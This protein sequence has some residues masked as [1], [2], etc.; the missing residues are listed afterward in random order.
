MKNTR[1]NEDKKITFSC[2]EGYCAQGESDF[3]SAHNHG[4][5]IIQKGYISE[6]EDGVLV[7]WQE[8]RNKPSLRIIAAITCFAFIITQTDLLWAFEDRARTLRPRATAEVSRAQEEPATS[9]G[10][11]VFTGSLDLP[12]PVASTASPEEPLVA[13]EE[14]SQGP[15]RSVEAQVP[16]TA[17]GAASVF[18]TSVG[19]REAIDVSS[20]DVKPAIAR[21][22]ARIALA[23]GGCLALLTAAVVAAVVGAPILMFLGVFAFLLLG[24]YAFLS[25]AHRYDYTG[26][27]YSEEAG[28]VSYLRTLA[29]RDPERIKNAIATTFGVRSVGL[30]TAHIENS[31]RKMG[32]SEEA[33]ARA[34]QNGDLWAAAYRQVHEA[35]FKKF[36][37]QDD[38]RAHGNVEAATRGKGFFARQWI[39]IKISLGI[40]LSEARASRIA[41]KA[42][43]LIPFYVLVRLPIHLF[44]MFI[45]RYFRQRFSYHNFNYDTL[46]YLGTARAVEE[47]TASFAESLSIQDPSMARGM[48]AVEKAKARAM[49]TTPLRV[50]SGLANVTGLSAVIP[51]LAKRAQLYL[52]SY[53]IGGHVIMPLLGMTILGIPGIA[54]V[55]LGVLAWGLYV[56]RGKTLAQKAA[57]IGAFTLGVV[58]LLLAGHFLGIPITEI[59]LPHLDATQAVVGQPVLTF[60]LHN[61]NATV[62]GVISPLIPSFYLQY[63]DTKRKMRGELVRQRF[64]DR[65]LAMMGVRGLPHLASFGFEDTMDFLERL[66]TEVV[67]GNVSAQDY[68]RALALLARIVNTPGI[69]NASFGQRLVLSRAVADLEAPLDVAIRGHAR[70]Q[71]HNE[72]PVDIDAALREVAD[73]ARS[74]TLWDRGFWTRVFSTTVGMWTVTAEISG[75]LLYSHALDSVVAPITSSLGHFVTGHDV[76][77]NP[78][79]NAASFIEGSHENGQGPQNLREAGALGWF[80]FGVDAASKA[81]FGFTPGQAMARVWHDA[82]MVGVST[83]A[84]QT[85][86]RDAR[87]P[88]RN[89]QEA[90]R[91]IKARAGDEAV[92][93]AMFWDFK[94][95]DPSTDFR[96]LAACGFNEVIVDGYCL[97]TDEVGVET[98]ARYIAA[99]H[100]AGIQSMRFMLGNEN[101]VYTERQA[102]VRITGGLCDKLQ[103]VSKQLERNGEDQAAEIIHGVAMDNE[104]YLLKEKWEQSGENA[105]PYCTLDRELQ[106][107]TEEKGFEY[108]R[109]ETYWMPQR[110]NYTPSGNTM[111]NMS[112][113]RNANTAVSISGTVGNSHAYVGGFDLVENAD[114]GGYKGAE[115]QLASDLPGYVQS[116]FAERSGNFK[117]IFVH[118]A[119]ISDFRNAWRQ[120][121]LDTSRLP[122]AG[123]PKGE[124]TPAPAPTPPAAV[125]AP[126]QVPA[127]GRAGGNVAQASQDIVIPRLPGPTIVDIDNIPRWVWE[128]SGKPLERTQTYPQKA[129]RILALEPSRN[130]A[131]MTGYEVPFGGAD[132]AERIQQGDL[133]WRQVADWFPASQVGSLPLEI[134]IELSKHVELQSTSSAVMLDTL[135]VIPSESIPLPADTVNHPVM[136]APDSS[137]TFRASIT[138]RDHYTPFGVELP[139]RPS[140]VMFRITISGVDYLQAQRIINAAAHGPQAEYITQK[141][142]YIDPSYGVGVLEFY[143]RDPAFPS[144]SAKGLNIHLDPGQTRTVELTVPGIS[145]EMGNRFT[146]SARVLDSYGRQLADGRVGGYS[147]N[148][149]MRDY[150]DLALSDPDA[151]RAFRGAVENDFLANKVLLRHVRAAF[152]PAALERDPQFERLDAKTKEV[153]IAL[154]QDILDLSTKVSLGRDLTDA[155]REVLK[156]IHMREQTTVIQIGNDRARVVSMSMTPHEIEPRGTTTLKARFENTGDVKKGQYAYVVTVRNVVTNEQERQTGYIVLEQHKPRDVEIPIVVNTPGR[157][158]ANVTLT[159][160]NFVYGD[161]IVRTQDRGYADFRV[162]AF[163]AEIGNVEQF[164]EAPVRTDGPQVIF[165]KVPVTNNGTMP[166]ELGIEPLS[167]LHINDKV[168]RQYPGIPIYG[169][170]LAPKESRTI[171]VPVVL[172]TAGNYHV[173][174]A[175]VSANA[176]EGAQVLRADSTAPRTHL[177]QETHSQKNVESRTA[178]GTATTAVLERGGVV[179]VRNHSGNEA[180]YTVAM[181]LYPPG[182]FTKPVRTETRELTVAKHDEESADLLSDTLPVGRYNVVYR[183][184]DTQ[185]RELCMLKDINDYSVSPVRV[186]DR[187]FKETALRRDATQIKE[188]D[189]DAADRILLRVAVDRAAFSDEEHTILATTLRNADSDAGSLLTDAEYRDNTGAARRALIDQRKAELRENLRGW[190]ATRIAFLPE[191]ETAVRDAERDGLDAA[192]MARQLKWHLAQGN[193]TQDA[194]R[195]ARDDAQG[196][197]DVEQVASREERDAFQRTMREETARRL[198]EARPWYVRFIEKARPTIIFIGLSVIILNI[199][200]WGIFNRRRRAE[201][202]TLIR[203]EAGE[204]QYGRVYITRGDQPTVTEDLSGDRSISDVFNDMVDQAQAGRQATVVQ[205]RGF[206]LP[207]GRV[208]NQTTAVS[209]RGITMNPRQCYIRL[210][211]YVSTVGGG[212]GN[213]GGFS[214]TYNFARVMIGDSMHQAYRTFA[215]MPFISEARALRMVVTQIM[216]NGDDARDLIDTHPELE[217]REIIQHA[218]DATDLGRLPGNQPFSDSLLREMEQ[219]ELNPFLLGV[220]SAML[221]RPV[222]PE[223]PRHIT[224]RGLWFLYSLVQPNLFLMREWLGSMGARYTISIRTDT[225]TGNLL[226]TYTVLTGDPSM[227]DYLVHVFGRWLQGHGYIQMFSYLGGAPFLIHA[228]TRPD[229]QAMRRKSEDGLGYFPIPTSAYVAQP[230]N[231]GFVRGWM[232]AEP[233]EEVLTYPLSHTNALED[234]VYCGKVTDTMIPSLGATTTGGILFAAS[235]LGNVM[236]VMGDDVYMLRIDPTN[237]STKA[238]NFNAMFQIARGE[239]ACLRARTAVPGATNPHSGSPMNPASNNEVVPMTTAQPV[240]GVSVLAPEQLQVFTGLDFDQFITAQAAQE[241]TRQQYDAAHP[242]EA[243]FGMLPPDPYNTAFGHPRVSDAIETVIGR[244]ATLSLSDAAIQDLATMI[245]MALPPQ[246]AGLSLRQQL[247]LS[248]YLGDEAYRSQV[249]EWI[250]RNVTA[251]DVVERNVEEFE[252]PAGITLPLEFSITASPFEIFTGAV[253]RTPGTLAMDHVARL[254][255]A[256]QVVEFAAPIAYARERELLR[257]PATR[258][259][260]RVPHMGMRLVNI[261]LDYASYTPTVRPEPVVCDF[262][263]ASAQVRTQSLLRDLARAVTPQVSDVT[264]GLLSPAEYT[265]LQQASGLIRGTADNYDSVVQNAARPDGIGAPTIPALIW[266]RRFFE[267]YINPANV[268]TLDAFVIRAL[269]NGRGDRGVLCELLRL[270]DDAGVWRPQLT[271]ALVYRHV[272]DEHMPVV[273]IA[274]EEAR[275]TLREE[276]ASTMQ[277]MGRL[278]GATADGIPDMTLGIWRVPTFFERMIARV[279]GEVMVSLFKPIRLAFHMAIG[280]RYD[281][282]RI[283]DEVTQEMSRRQASATGLL[284]RSQGPV[285][286]EI[287]CAPQQV[288]AAFAATGFES[289]DVHVGGIR[290]LLSDAD[291]ANAMPAPGVIDIFTLRDIFRTHL[292]RANRGNPVTAGSGYVDLVVFEVLQALSNAGMAGADLLAAQII[293]GPGYNAMVAA[294]VQRRAAEDLCIGSRLPSQLYN[295]SESDRVLRG[296]EASMQLGNNTDAK[297]GRRSGRFGKINSIISL[298]PGR[299]VSRLRSWLF[300]NRDI[301]EG[302]T[303]DPQT[304]RVRPVSPHQIH[305]EATVSLVPGTVSPMMDEALNRLVDLLKDEGVFPEVVAMFVEEADGS[306]RFPRVGDTQIRVV[307]CV[308]TSQTRQLGRDLDPILRRVLGYWRNVD[309]IAG[310]VDVQ[311]TFISLDQLDAALSSDAAFRDAVNAGCCVQRVS[312]YEWYTLDN[313][314]ENFAEWSIAHS[315]LEPNTT[316]LGRV[317]RGEHGPEAAPI[318]VGQTVPIPSAG[319]PLALPAESPARFSRA[320]AAELNAQ[321]EQ[322]QAIARAA[323]AGDPQAQAWID[324]W[325]DARVQRAIDSVG[326]DIAVF[327]QC[328]GQLGITVDE[329]CARVGITVTPQQIVDNFCPLSQEALTRGRIDLTSPN[330]A[331]DMLS[332]AAERVSRQ[333]APLNTEERLAVLS[334]MHQRYVAAALTHI[335]RLENDGTLDAQQ[336]ANARQEILDHSIT[337]RDVENLDLD[338][339]RININPDGTLDFTPGDAAGNLIKAELLRELQEYEMGLSSD[340]RMLVSL[341][342]PI[343]SLHRFGLYDTSRYWLAFGPVPLWPGKIIGRVPLL[344]KPLVSTK[345]VVDPDMLPVLTMREYAG[346]PTLAAPLSGLSRSLPCNPATA[347]C[348]LTEDTWSNEWAGGRAIGA[349]PA[350]EPFTPGEGNI[351][352]EVLVATRETEQHSNGV[353]RAFQITAHEGVAFSLEHMA[354]DLIDGPVMTRQRSGRRRDTDFLTVCRGLLSLHT[355]QNWGE[356]V[357]TGLQ[358]GYGWLNYL[359]FGGTAEQLWWEMAGPIVP[360]LARA[361]REGVVQDALRGKIPI[362]EVEE[363]VRRVKGDPTGHL[364]PIDPMAVLALANE[365]SPEVVRAA[366]A[367]H[368]LLRALATEYS[369]EV[370]DAVLAYRANRTALPAGLLREDVDAVS[371]RLAREE[372]SLSNGVRSAVTRFERDV[373]QYLVAVDVGEFMT[374]H[375][376][377]FTQERVHESL[378]QGQWREIAEVHGVLGVKVIVTN[379]TAEQR[380]SLLLRTDTQ[381]L[382]EI[383]APSPGAAAPQT[384]PPSAPE[385]ALVRVNRAMRA[386]HFRGG[387]MTAQAL[388]TGIFAGLIAFGAKIIMGITANIAA[389]GFIGGIV[390][391]FT[392]TAL[393]TGAAALALKIAVPIIIGILVYALVKLLISRTRAIAVATPVAGI[394]GVTAAAAT[395]LGVLALTGVKVAAVATTA[396]AVALVAGK[397]L[398]GVIAVLAVVYLISYLC[399]RTAAGRALGPIVSDIFG[400][401]VSAGIGYFVTALLAKWGIIALTALTGGIGIGIAVLVLAIILPLALRHTGINSPSKLFLTVAMWLVDFFYLQAKAYRNDGRTNILRIIGN[402][403]LAAL[404]VSVIGFFVSGGSLATTIIVAAMA[405]FAVPSLIALSIGIVAIGAILAGAV[406]LIHALSPRTGPAKAWFALGVAAGIIALVLLIPSILAVAK[407]LFLAVGFAAGVLTVLGLVAALVLRIIDRVTGGVTGARIEALLTS[408]AGLVQN[409]DFVNNLTYLFVNVVVRPLFMIAGIIRVP[410]IVLNNFMQA[411]LARPITGLSGMSDRANYVR[412][413]G[414]RVERAVADLVTEEAVGDTASAFVTTNVQVIDGLAATV[415]DGFGDLFLDCAATVL[416]DASR[417]HGVITIAHQEIRALAEIFRG[418][419]ADAVTAVLAQYQAAREN[420]RFAA[421]LLHGIARAQIDGELPAA[422]TMLE[423][424]ATQTTFTQV[425]LWLEGQAVAS[426]ILGGRTIAEACWDA[427]NEAARRG[428]E[429]MCIIADS[430]NNNN[431]RAIPVTMVT[432]VIPAA[433]AAATTPAQLRMGTNNARIVTGAYNATILPIDIEN[434]RTFTG[435]FWETVQMSA[436]RG[437]AYLSAALTYLWVVR[438]ENADFITGL[439]GVERPALPGQRDT[440]LDMGLVTNALLRATTPEEFRSLIYGIALPSAAPIAPAPA[441]VDDDV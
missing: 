30:L 365:Y 58:G 401:A 340:A 195:M 227:L 393:L 189:L 219:M 353:W 234:I 392:T 263:F 154:E 328:A 232:S 63:F 327:T 344:P 71:A 326:G 352:Q 325:N 358:D 51:F 8:P 36:S 364:W 286:A 175:L 1:E 247:A 211:D 176:D 220:H 383:A 368:M 18:A 53:V 193:S 414:N 280:A 288:R 129:V 431:N 14:P 376:V 83:A 56:S 343:P 119:F 106:R 433:F 145:P 399:R 192:Y 148:E 374:A 386:L 12:G 50:L 135:E 34:M 369:P 439:V 75:V 441:D 361:H 268:E 180:R 269:C 122:Q 167:T 360:G 171:I 207:D 96:A 424:P 244:Q 168:V 348:E 216:G 157:Y 37:E 255:R 163:N 271:G 102:A 304:G 415:P 113:S 243:A 87:A 380:T 91:T 54:L 252:V 420:P 293:T 346:M 139:A 378:A 46:D 103:E 300:G 74:A 267:N 110:P 410:L 76:A 64:F 164:I 322:L 389:A 295:G 226:G 287:S 190:I 24:Y 258:T 57:V 146:F 61:F 228:E 23:V 5:N 72:M 205:L 301:M 199:L 254:S 68:A 120:W 279:F 88:L 423:D 265:A 335:D 299:R 93:S 126:E 17:V 3:F 107:V 403:L 214:N 331:A 274:E 38:T 178:S 354:T 373:A 272:H 400:V 218:I 413:A 330:I 169:I 149:T 15:S 114:G 215:S 296:G 292:Q 39:K 41:G 241:T 174:Y 201:L 25:A 224:V 217:P 264:A 316:E 124:E 197:R 294:A 245:P 398:L 81:T 7:D 432:R 362:S 166:V 438:D 237:A 187:E 387:S 259:R 47:I 225:N 409:S 333:L 407:A 181:E 206:R 191:E 141:H 137:V 277:A 317:L 394:F 307:I 44:D 337:A 179:R 59:G 339:L 347:L 155:E 311:E 248:Y 372:A 276:A 235:G 128:N 66:R 370:V 82:S 67:A 160:M 282:E 111:Y 384:T 417:S 172:P 40:S 318:P 138:N 406:W 196:H 281:P 156:A 123:A 251:D 26:T 152:E 359:F 434:N 6:K 85:S 236:M 338:R 350:L 121:G 11:D 116:S 342:S 435:R 20:I 391:T 381:A 65:P 204:G 203:I 367:H 27:A 289:T 419:Q 425:S 165:G 78:F 185:G 142:Y 377:P 49:R 84:A 313:Q 117:G 136:I 209:Q 429:P 341:F 73:E 270:R 385:G 10:R 314:G 188:G 140:D 323:L 95:V 418:P 436:E 13:D 356:E 104:P 298:F 285:P 297:T 320:Y 421:A 309:P 94:N 153:V 99:A 198:D 336:A 21:P 4:Y 290:L 375:I 109:I 182:D 100:D 257:D 60:F 230:R 239:I 312:A 52:F 22:W 92:V 388:S 321:I 260:N 250:A 79:Y 127:P 363:Y 397:I 115:R 315:E 332:T 222:F 173:S 210:Q 177:V 395:A 33:I 402:V 355:Q 390:K 134:A 90:A 302:G 108:R 89:M 430:L 273:D 427:I 150:L 184:R 16:D 86:D 202:P 334:A 319:A 9:T 144:D 43:V 186:V 55:A 345:H 382:D 349:L 256:A 130:F 379:R 422:V 48:S 2:D 308:P 303:R 233:T 284:S 19:T 70:L 69:M 246:C 428:V 97:V 213:Q 125:P 405:L 45:L 261:T 42:A 131:G 158:A 170:S 411:T 161:Y 305:S 366:L 162:G 283:H 183:V 151:V 238:G 426:P 77:V 240:Q 80:N 29:S 404:V 324:A 101:W 194:I 159:P 242:H 31:L 278:S 143:Y 275:Q 105:G 329:W 262:V 291:I 62:G 118:A 408:P 266:Q 396:L 35:N 147:I 412:T 32:F 132:I 221:L 416:E 231:A 440:A 223:R 28:S 249:Y 112:Y 357:E 437:Y 351:R 371:D 229:W 306:V 253:I 200:F 98:A 310:S 208:I 212:R 133:G